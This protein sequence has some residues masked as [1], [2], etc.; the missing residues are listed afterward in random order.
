MSSWTT[1]Y[2][3]IHRPEGRERS[4]APQASTG[5]AGAYASQSAQHRHPRAKHRSFSSTQRLTSVLTVTQIN[6]PLHVYST[7][8]FKHAWFTTHERSSPNVR[9]DAKKPSATHG[10]RFFKPRTTSELNLQGWETSGKDGHLRV[11]F[12]P[13]AT[14]TKVSRTGI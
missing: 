1:P 14:R 13:D 11:K 5:N 9:R 2:H 4:R 3:A 7:V 8:V 6:R 12:N 10:H